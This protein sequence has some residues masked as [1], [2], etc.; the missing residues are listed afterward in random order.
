MGEA[1]LITFYI[2]L[3]M[4]DHI[5]EKRENL[6]LRLSYLILVSLLYYFPSLSHFSPGGEFHA[7]ATNLG[8]WTY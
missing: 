2:E 3:Q 5:L 4:K 7:S 1:E 6:T 8:R